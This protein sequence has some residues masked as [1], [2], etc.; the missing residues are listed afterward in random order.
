M[1]RAKFI[2]TATLSAAA[3]VS[4]V[5]ASGRFRRDPLP[6]DSRPSAKHFGAMVSIPAGTFLMGN[7]L[8]ADSDRYPAHDVY[9]GAFRMDEHEVT[10]RQF[11]E[12]AEQTRYVTTAE[13]RGWSYVFDRRQKQWTRRT[14]ADWRHPQGPDS[15][16]HGRDGLPA[17]HVSW[18]DARAYAKWAG[19]QLPTEAQWEYAAR[20]GL[21]DVNYPWGRDE[22]IDGRYRANYRQHGKEPAADGY[23]GLAPVK[24]FP[25]SSFGLY[26]I[27]GNVWEWCSDWYGEHY[28]RQCAR[29][30]PAGPV[31]GQRRVQRGGSWL[32]PEDYRFGHHVSARGKRPPEETYEHVGFRCVR[33][34]RSRPR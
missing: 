31:K 4:A 3:V 7:D 12:F 19:K 26:D 18:Y 13:Q 10:N 30:D 25:A 28:Y 22:L 23:E 8:S 33:P 17:V 34:A 21:R 9:V 6:V 5:W 11:R 16:L 2:A 27:S 32:S 1:A 20:S 14:G 24:S 29:D 15:S